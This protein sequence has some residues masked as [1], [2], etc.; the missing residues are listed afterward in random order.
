MVWFII[1]LE[2]WSII[3]PLFLGG[4]LNSYC[5]TVLNPY[6]LNSIKHVKH[7]N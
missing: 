7:I 1:N 6:T 5:S 2:C 4:L 3:H